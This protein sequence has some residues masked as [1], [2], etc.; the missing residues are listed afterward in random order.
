[1][2]S[3][4]NYKFNWISQYHFDERVNIIKYSMERRT[5]TLLI[6]VSASPIRY[7]SKLAVCYHENTS[8][9][10]SHISFL[11]NYW[12]ITYFQKVHFDNHVISDISIL[13][14]SP[15]HF[16]ITFPFST[17]FC[18][19]AKSTS[20]SNFENILVFYAIFYLQ[21]RA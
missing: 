15:F 5:I 2:Y 18:L 3:E 16:I 19:L 14:W 8:S 21:E 7:C 9:I 17:F 20:F 1:M 4:M 10:Y 6:M 13:H 12:L 11:P